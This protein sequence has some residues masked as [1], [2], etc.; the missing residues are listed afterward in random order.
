[1]QKQSMRLQPQTY[2]FAHANEVN[3]IIYNTTDKYCVRILISFQTRGS[4]ESA[5]K[6]RDIRETSIWGFWGDRHLEG[7]N[8]T[9]G[10][11]TSKVSGETDIRGET[12]QISATAASIRCKMMVGFQT[13]LV[14]FWQALCKRSTNCTI[15]CNCTLFHT[16]V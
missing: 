7:H 6:E 2:P 16:R 12:T 14:C 15:M 13:H 4:R 9:L 11:Q 5:G 10:Q 8:E 3:G 1:L